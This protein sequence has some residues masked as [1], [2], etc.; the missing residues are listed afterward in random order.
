MVYIKDLETQIN[1]YNIYEKCTPDIIVAPSR[2]LGPVDWPRA[3]RMYEEG[4]QELW[5]AVGEAHAGRKLA[6]PEF[7]ST[8][9]KWKDRH[10]Q[11][12]DALL[13]IIYKDHP[14]QPSGE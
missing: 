2:D 4:M 13:R 5:R 12:G 6:E 7:E 14:P 10:T 9:G 3:I 11:P 1:W 8:Y